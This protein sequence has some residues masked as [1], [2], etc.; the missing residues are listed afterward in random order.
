MKIISGLMAVTVAVLGV[1]PARAEPE[2]FSIDSR[3]TFPM[4]EVSHFG[5]S[6]QRGRFE[7]T[8]GKV[9]LDREARTGSIDITIDAASVSMGFEKWNEHMRAEGLFNTTKHPVITFRSD[10]LIFD[11][12]KPVAAD[13]EFTLLGVTQP[14]RIKVAGFAC[15]QHP[16]LNKLYCGAE[17]TAQIKR[18]EFGM[19]KGI[20]MVSDEV[21]LF[22]TVEAIKD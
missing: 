4:F 8:S 21:K 6:T 18:S 19:T 10:K 16:K 13:G 1:V 12:D 17:I 11:G 22:S 3:H 5:I 2:S 15:T 20:P 7:K 14:L 9:L